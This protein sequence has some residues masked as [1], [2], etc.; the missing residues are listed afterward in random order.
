MGLARPR[1]FW[2]RKIEEIMANAPITNIY[3]ALE[4]EYTY[5]PYEIDRDKHADV[6]NQFN[7]RNV[8]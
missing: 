3:I 6:K 4:L 1:N 7:K 8:R 5:L 2:R